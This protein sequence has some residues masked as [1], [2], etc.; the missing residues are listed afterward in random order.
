M[1]RKSRI[2]ALLPPSR[3]LGRRLLGVAGLCA[4]ASW[5]FVPSA[6]AQDAP[7][8]QVIVHPKN[9]ATSANRTLIAD[10]F[11]KKATRWENGDAAVPVDQRPSSGV[12]KAFSEDVL[13]RSVEAVRNYWTQR[14]FAGRELPPP[15][16]DSDEAVVRFVAN[17][18]GALGYVSGN[19][20]LG[21]C[22]R[23]EV[24]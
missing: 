20:P 10:I 11:L 3:K 2:D 23:L 14:I 9:P 16:V 17:H 13:R 21:P 7:A 1:S 5:S 18:P 8:Y 22:K 6:G 19:A 24:R 4:V 15:E 12:R